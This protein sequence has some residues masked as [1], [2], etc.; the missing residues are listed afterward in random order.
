M[1]KPEKEDVKIVSCVVVICLAVAFIVLT[2][3]NLSHAINTSPVSPD[4]AYVI[5]TTAPQ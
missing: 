4:A 3:G 5:D 2:L 1:I